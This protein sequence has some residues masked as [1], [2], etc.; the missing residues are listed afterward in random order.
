MTYA[1]H[2]TAWEEDELKD[3]YYRVSLGDS[4]QK[5]VR[6]FGRSP[7]AIK[8]ALRKILAVQLANYPKSRVAEA[9][10]MDTEVLKAYLAS[11]KYEVPLEYSANH[12]GS[13]GCYAICMSSILLA[14]AFCIFG[15]VSNTMVATISYL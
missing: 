2:Y 4:V 1:N 8:D 9:L 10:N 13:V 6:R 3:L 12:D 5:L 11:E 14:G 15:I 7:Q